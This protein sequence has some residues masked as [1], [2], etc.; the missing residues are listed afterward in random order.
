MAVGYTPIPTY[1]TPVPAFDLVNELNNIINQI[2]ANYISANG[3]E[4]APALPWVAARFYG[5]PRGC[6]PSTLLTIA[7]TIYAYPL[8]IPGNTAIKT[9]SI[10]STTGQTGGALHA[11]I[12]FDNGGI[13]GTLVPG[14]DS[15]ALAATGTAVATATYAAALNLT[16]GWY[17][18]A[19]LATAS[20]TYPTVAALASAY[21]NEVNGEMGIDTAAHLFATSSQNSLGVTGTATYGALPAT[22]PTPAL[23]IATAIPMVGLGT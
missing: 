7:S 15:G 22:F 6:T 1:T 20:G 8:Y 19:T 5:L 4:V 14:S 13:P 21:T 2:N 10:D 17:W 23:N 16:P 3:P 18:L 9:I 11:G 12:Y